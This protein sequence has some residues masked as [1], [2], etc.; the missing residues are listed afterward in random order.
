MS[1]TVIMKMIALYIHRSK[2]GKKYVVIIGYN[3]NGPDECEEVPEGDH[4]VGVVSPGLLN[5]AAQLRV[6]VRPHHGEDSGEDPDHQRHV[7][8][9]GVLTEI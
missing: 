1:Y 6:A 4:D 3:Q 8:R 5:H 9:P 7:D 2:K